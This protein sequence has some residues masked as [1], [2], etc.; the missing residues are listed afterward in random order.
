[1]NLHET[2]GFNGSEQAKAYHDAVTHRITDRIQWTDPR[3]AKIVRLRLL[4]DA[5]YPAWDVSYCHGQLK[6]GSYVDVEL[7]FSQL[8]KGRSISS[9]IVAYAQRDKVYARGLGILSS[10]STFN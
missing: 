2:N 7:P 5:G 3:L 9:Q 10:I 6:D 1:M 8:A 4:S